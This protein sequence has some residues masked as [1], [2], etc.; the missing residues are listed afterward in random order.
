MRKIITIICTV[1]LLAGCT[2]KTAIKGHITNGAD[3]TLYI[4]HI[5][6]TKT[7]VVDS[8]T[9]NA[10]G[11]FAFK[12][13]RAKYPD[14]Y[15]L[16]LANQNI[17]L[18]VD[19]LTER[20]DIQCSADSMANATIS[21]SEASNDIQRLRRSSL[22]LQTMAEHKMTNDVATGLESHRKLAEEIILKDTRSIA[23]YY[24]IYQTIYGYYY[25]SPA[26]KS[27]LQLWSAVATA[28]DVYFPEYDRSKEL[29]ATTLAAIRQQ[30]GVQIDAEQIL[31]SSERTGFIEIALPNRADETTKLSSLKGSVVLVDFT[32]YG[33]EQA[34]AHTLFMRELYEKY[35][36][37]GLK[38][39]QVS[40]DANKLF[41]LE[42]TV[43]IPWI[44]VRDKNGP[45]SKTALQYNVTELPTFFLI[46][47]DGD[48]VGRFNHENIENEISTLL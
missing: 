9:L 18:G 7:E 26:E 19:S 36:H 27:G 43:D 1:L 3:K 5:S 34:V 46:N 25:I 8:T 28:Y 11:K 33:I 4:E 17:V 24:A 37:N 38:I 29:K 32:A 47:R 20:I 12:V 45:D 23:A 44:C 13:E 6:L 40:L 10:K 35:R 48:I 16:R 21:G 41:W 15:R 30:R 14:L 2:E 22:A 39:Y 42:Q 31:A